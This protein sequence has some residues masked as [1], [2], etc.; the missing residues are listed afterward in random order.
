MSSVVSR[1]K[2]PP[3]I[4]YAG[5]ASPRKHPWVLLASPAHPSLSPSFLSSR[6]KIFRYV[7][8]LSAVDALRHFVERLCCRNVP[9]V[10]IHSFVPYRSMHSHFLTSA[11]IPQ[12]NHLRCSDQMVGFW[13]R[14]VVGLALSSQSIVNG[15]C[16]CI[17]SMA[18]NVSA[19]EAGVPRSVPE[20]VA[21]EL[22]KAGD[23]YLVVR[24]VT[25]QLI[26]RCN[27]SVW[28]W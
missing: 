8:T 5:R 4:A 9:M 14:D 17:R 13:F 22:L 15:F 27:D 1:V 6:G 18:S 20:A 11:T 26:R 25:V 21:H 10:A 3:F 24:L 23:R 19:E 2:T 28:L 7:F 12:P 16:S